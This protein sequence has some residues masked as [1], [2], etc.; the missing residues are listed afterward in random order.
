MVS[1]HA[2]IGSSTLSILVHDIRCYLRVP[3]KPRLRSIGQVLRFMGFFWV[4]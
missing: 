2:N 3:G 1:S 4:K